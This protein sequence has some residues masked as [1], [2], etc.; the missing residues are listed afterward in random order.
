MFVVL[1]FFPAKKFCFFDVFCSCSKDYLSL[2]RNP[3]KD[4]GLFNKMTVQLMLKILFSKTVNFLEYA[5]PFLY[6][7]YFS[8]NFVAF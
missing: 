5:N 1:F 7:L 2:K 3:S 6:T 4:G 8:N